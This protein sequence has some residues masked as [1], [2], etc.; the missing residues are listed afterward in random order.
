MY[1]TDAKFHKLAIKDNQWLGIIKGDYTKYIE[2]ST[3]SSVESIDGFINIQTNVQITKA[4]I[5]NAVYPYDTQIK[6]IR[7]NSA[8]RNQEIFEDF[9]AFVQLIP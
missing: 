2:E 5:I 4:E 8:G 1:I 7:D 3:L 6:I 9:D